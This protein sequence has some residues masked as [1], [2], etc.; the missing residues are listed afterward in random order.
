MSAVTAIHSLRIVRVDQITLYYESRN[1]VKTA[2][3]GYDADISPVPGSITRSVRTEN[4]ITYTDIAFAVS[5]VTSRTA[6]L[7]EALK[8]TRIVVMCKDE[9]GSDLIF[10][11]P[12]WPA[13]LNYV[14]EGS[15]YKVTITAATPSGDMFLIP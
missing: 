8:A 15:V 5:E 13:T 3:T 6:S 10:G 4:S 9:R 12:G 1:R 14:R 2:Y 7:L 11:S